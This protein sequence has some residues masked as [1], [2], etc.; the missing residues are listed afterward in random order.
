MRVNP[1]VCILGFSDSIT[2][3][4]VLDIIRSGLNL[5]F[6]W[7]KKENIFTPLSLPKDFSVEIAIVNAEGF[8]D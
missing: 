8:K 5:S 7:V 2:D 6:G 4:L 1:K 3:E